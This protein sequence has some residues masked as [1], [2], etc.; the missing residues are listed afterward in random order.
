MTALS[1]FQKFSV[2]NQPLVSKTTRPIQIKPKYVQ[3]FDE[4]ILDVRFINHRYIAYG[5]VTK[6]FIYEQSL[7]QETGEYSQKPIQILNLK[8]QLS[9]DRFIFSSSLDSQYNKLM[10]L[11]YIQNEKDMEDVNQNAIDVVKIHDCVF[12]E[13]SFT[14][15]SPW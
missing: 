10:K 11:S 15:S 13:S 1:K 8:S 9:N 3:W 4:S 12:P 6:M 2:V 5:F 7:S 14:I